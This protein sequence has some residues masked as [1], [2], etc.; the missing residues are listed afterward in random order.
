[1]SVRVPR[2]SPLLQSSWGR[3]GAALEVYGAACGP[4]WAVLGH[5][6][7]PIGAI[8]GTSWAASACRE[9]E[10]TTTP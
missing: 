6:W 5:P 9:R 10:Q 1:M 3:F 2:L 4:S 8:F 7:R